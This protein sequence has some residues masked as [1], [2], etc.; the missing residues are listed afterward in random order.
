M[1]TFKFDPF[2]TRYEPQ[3]ALLFAQAANLA[4]E[5]DANKVTTQLTRWGFSE[6]YIFDK[7]DTQGFITTDEN[8]IVVSFRGT[9]PDALIDWFTDLRV[10]LVPGPKGKVHRGFLEALETV[11]SDVW[12]QIQK[13]QERTKT[14]TLITGKGKSVWFT[15]HSLGAALA[16][17][18]AARL[19]LEMDRGVFGLYTFGSPRVGDRTFADA[20]DGVFK[21]YTFRFV[22]NNDLVTRVPLR[23]MEYSHVGTFV[24]LD[25]DGKLHDDTGF[26]WIFLD[27]IQGQIK[28]FLKPGSDGLKDHAIKNYVDGINKNPNWTP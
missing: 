28:D 2:S 15:G 21:R 12:K 20:F 3:K 18:A 10:W 8:M 11:W 16:T 22:N 14:G 6:A 1:T 25:K 7:K 26:W 27:Q 5:K 24:Y 17:L 4:Y 23:E 9:Q 19:R 13:F